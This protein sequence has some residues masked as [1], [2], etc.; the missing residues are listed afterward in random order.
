MITVVYH[1]LI[2]NGKDTLYLLANMKST[3]KTNS[4]SVLVDPTPRSY[5][6][7][8]RASSCAARRVVTK[9]YS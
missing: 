6:Q 8:P 7:Q 1:V 3:A 4:S 2:M 5:F 9:A